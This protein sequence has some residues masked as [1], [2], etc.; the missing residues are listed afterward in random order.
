MGTDLWAT[1]ATI[2]TSENRNM[3]W[4]YNCGCHRGSSRQEAVGG[5]YGNCGLQR[6]FQWPWCHGSNFETLW[7]TLIHNFW[8]SCRETSNSLGYW[9]IWSFNYSITNETEGLSNGWGAL[10]LVT[11]AVYFQI[12]DCS[13]QGTAC[14]GIARLGPSICHRSGFGRVGCSSR[15]SQGDWFSRLN[16]IYLSIVYRCFLLRRLGTTSLCGM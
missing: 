3:L 16:W 2:Q 13:V 6:H 14:H 7:T 5:Q 15:G 10:S 11:L 1:W 8:W 9:Y 4:G 12:W